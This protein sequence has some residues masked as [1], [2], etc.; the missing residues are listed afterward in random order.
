MTQTGDSSGDFIVVANRL[1]VEPIYANDDPDQAIL[2]W[3]RAPGGLVSALDPVLRNRTSVWVGAG[4]LCADDY[5]SFGNTRLEPVSIPADDFQLYYAGF[6]NTA[7]WPLYHSAIVTPEFHRDQFDAYKRVTGLF[8]RS[9]GAL[10]AQQATVWVHDYQLQL[11]PGHLREQRPDLR[12][13][14]FLHIPFPPASLFSQ[15]PWRAQILSGLLGSDLVGFQ[16]QQDV[17][18]FI[19]ACQRI[20]G[21]RT[22]DG[23]IL[24][25]GRQVRVGAFPI[26][27]DADAYSEMAKDPAVQQRAKELR[28]ELGQ[29]KTLMLGVDR[30]DYTKGIDI[31]LRAFAE[32]LESKRLDPSSTV[33]VQVAVPTRGDVREY[34]TI[35]DEVELLVGRFNG[36]LA[37]I[38]AN[39]INYLHRVLTPEELVALYLAADIMLVTPLR[40]GMNLVAKEYV[41][42]RNDNSGALVL[43]EFTGSAAQLTDAWL[44]NPYDTDSVEQAIS[45]AVTASAA[46]RAQRMQSMREVVFDFDVNSW[47][48]SFLDL[49]ESNSP[50]PEV[51]SNPL[52]IPLRTLAR[53]PHLLVCCDYDGTLAPLVDDPA[54]ARPLSEAITALRQI[55][56][57]PSTTVAV[58]SGRSLRDLAALSR[59]PPEI[60]LVGSHGSE[61]DADFRLDAQQLRLLEQVKTSVDEISGSVAA[62]HV[63][64]K[65]GSLAVH[66]RR[67]KEQDREPLI[68]Q[69]AMG[70]GQFPGVHIR[71]GKDVIELSVTDTQKS[72]AVSALRHRTGASAV[73]FIGDDVTDES[74]FETLAG[75]DV[76][77]KV[78]NGPTAAPWRVSGPPEVSRVLSDL[79][80]LRQAWLLGGHAVPIEDYTLLSSMSNVA[81]LSPQGSIDWFCAPE[82][83]SPAI[84]AA[85]LGDTSSGFFSIMPAGERRLLAQSYQRHSLSVQTRWAGLTIADFMPVAAISSPSPAAIIRR[86]SGSVPARIVFAPRPLFG[87]IATTI[88]IRDEGLRVTAGSESLALYAP[89]IEWDI[90]EHAGQQTATATVDPSAGPISLELR[91]GA[92]DEAASITESSAIRQEKTSAFWTSWLTSLDLPGIR[93]EAE[94]RAALTLRALCHQ[95]T[96]A[97]LAAATTSLPESLGG[98]RNWDYRFCWIRDAALTA[99]ELVS[100]GSTAEAEAFLAWLKSVDSSAPG[101]ESLRPVY[102]LNGDGLGAEAVIESLPGYAGSRPVR[103]GN[104]AQ[105]QLQIDVFGAVCL[106]IDQLSLSRASVTDDEWALTQSMVEA[107]ARRWREPDH[108]IWEIR[109]KPKHH[110][111]S[112]MMCWLAINAGV[113]IAE[114]AAGDNSGEVHAWMQLRSEIFDEIEA[115]NWSEQVKSY[116]AATDHI[117]AD[118]AVLQ[119]ILEGYPAPH[120][121]IVGTVAY[122]EQELRHGGGVYRYTYDDGL[123]HGE[124]AMHI[125]AAWLAAT[126]VHMGA[127]DDALQLLDAMLASAGVTG[128]LPEQVDPDTNRGLGNHPQAYSH[129]GVLTVCRILAQKDSNNSL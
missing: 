93:I 55:S 110:T 125:C 109:D 84:F 89:G 44:V 65:P 11:L 37:Q 39:P 120:E 41:A 7:I 62:A 127:S 78:G 49:L 64:T 104:A 69:I 56:L 112:R 95:P 51:S 119:G 21:L 6:S 87:T 16:S 115:S 124:G 106:L 42:C 23:K 81:L 116:I 34:Q 86:L 53:T 4:D 105:G 25:D 40:D 103:V 54:K 114:R 20:L 1:P 74:V 126:Y 33:L 77:V 12:I 2:S 71:Y 35:R 18:H 30:L 32:L 122:I 27:I 38:G 60:H 48:N 17:S 121:R 88:E 59:L 26:G 76:G 100:V 111:H 14:F 5:G 113:A 47:A 94:K 73:L 117:D 8:A 50:A 96:G 97:I 58:V 19:D 101:L 9:V 102:R 28:V 72:D 68:R 91:Y 82:P 13:G 90:T 108:G 79:H 22:E 75:P 45:D 99:R 107:V 85:L 36:S 61:V 66:V 67:C 70:P 43:S 24:F 10:A 98:V 129:L 29:P 123:P 118:A 92:Y 46:D 31:R 52:E 57:L 3:H 128:L 15:L 83:D 80:G 63:E